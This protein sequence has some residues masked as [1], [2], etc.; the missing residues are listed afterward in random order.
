[1][2]VRE[3][4]NDEK[5]VQSVLKKIGLSEIPNIDEVRK[6]QALM[7]LLSVHLY[8]PLSIVGWKHIKTFLTSCTSLLSLRA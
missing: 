3:H 6:Y 8:N 2:V 4:L 1:V 7:R 5:K